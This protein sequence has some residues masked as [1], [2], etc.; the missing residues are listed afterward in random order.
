MKIAVFLYSPPTSD[1]TIKA[2][3]FCQQAVKDGHTIE[4]VF[5]YQDGVYLANNLMV[6]PQGELNIQHHFKAFAKA[7][8][9]RLIACIASCLRRGVLTQ[10]EATRHTKAAGNFDAQFELA[11]L[12][13]YFDACHSTDKI[14][15]F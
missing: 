10:K 12:G 6:T 9:T 7:Y 4:R 3:E 8:K 14:V 11:G 13:E 1:N 2:L 5:C 15:E